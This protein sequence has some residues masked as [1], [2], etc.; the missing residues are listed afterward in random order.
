LWKGT[1]SPLVLDDFHNLAPLLNEKKPN[2][3]NVILSNESGPLG[4]SVSMMTF[5]VNH[6]VRGSI[7]AVDLKI[8]NLFIHLTNALLLY[9][10]LVLLLKEKYF[11]EHGN[12]L[13]FAITLCWLF[14]PINTSVLFYAVQRMAML[15]TLFVLAGCL[16]YVRMRLFPLRGSHKKII[17]SLLILI[18]WMLATLSKENGILLPVFILVIELCF[19]DELHLIIKNISRNKAA[20]Y[21][22]GS[23]LLIIFMVS[24]INYKGYFNY[25]YVDFNLLDRLFTQPVVLI[26]YIYRLFLPF[27]M[28]IGLISDDVLIMTTFWNLETIISSLVL[29]SIVAVCLYSLIKDKYRYLS[30]GLLFYLCGHLIESTVFPLEMYFSH[31]NYLPSVG[32]YSFLCLF[33]DKCFYYIGMSRLYIPLFAI[34]VSLFMFFS[35]ERSKVWNSEERIALNAYYYHPLSVRANM[36]MVELLKGKGKI[37]EA[38]EINNKMFKSKSYDVFRP[39]IQRLYLYCWAGKR[40][41]EYEYTKFSENI[42]RHH[43]IETSNALQNLLDIVHDTNCTGVDFVM[44]SK[45]LSEWIDDKIQLNTYSSEQLWHLEYYVIEFM[46]V[47]EHKEFAMQR[48]KRFADMGNLNAIQYYKDINKNDL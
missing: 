23:S 12:M 48:L 29:T 37:E 35:Y 7:S 39:I 41:P 38:F 24:I 9:L 10:L 36:E 19:F 11:S 31:R 26:D 34:Y 20:A 25:S 21:L 17:S 33:I 5:A 1:D 3:L 6:W 45:D 28:D 40:L 32:L 22:M 27:N 8:T 30:F 15:S 16:L 18:C 47:S 42:E 2:Y 4:R 14:S 44:I 43:V 13:A 46:L